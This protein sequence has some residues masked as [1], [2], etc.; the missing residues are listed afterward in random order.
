M[1]YFKRGRS[2]DVSENVSVNSDP[3]IKRLSVALGA[4]LSCQER[5]YITKLWPFNHFGTNAVYVYIL[6]RLTC[7]TYLNTNTR[8]SPRT[9]NVRACILPIQ[10]TGLDTTYLPSLF[11]LPLLKLYLQY[12][13]KGG[14]CNTS[15][16]SLS[17]PCWGLSLARMFRTVFW[18]VRS[19]GIIRYWTASHFWGCEVL[20]LVRGTILLRRSVLRFLSDELQ[21][22]GLVGQGGASGRAIVCCPLPT[23]R[24]GLNC[25]I[26]SSNLLPQ[27]P[28][29]LNARFALP[30]N[31]EPNRQTNKYNGMPVSGRTSVDLRRRNE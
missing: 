19:V 27:Q 7:K 17:F 18:C 13:T 25:V 1:W 28:V 29:S 6:T 20:L 14:S 11:K 30:K 21:A 5:Y 15:A 22:E 24:H 23:G 3:P 2:E 9:T 10:T 26:S 16:F 12:V 31:R 8:I 4:F